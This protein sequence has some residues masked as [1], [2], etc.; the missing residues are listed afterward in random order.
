MSG[1]LQLVA[2]T[3]VVG[4]I[5]PESVPLWASP[6][7]S[8][9]QEL[10]LEAL[11]ERQDAVF[12]ETGEEPDWA[13]TSSKQYRLLYQQLQAQVRFNGDGGLQAG[14]K[15][16]LKLGKTLVERQPDCP[17]RCFWL[18]TKSD[19]I[20][21]RGEGPQWADEKYGGTSQPVQYVSGTTKVK[22]A[23]VYRMQVGLKQRNSHSGLTA[24]K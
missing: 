18:L 11:Y 16:G 24:L 13:L 7:D 2:E 19:L 12:Q 20:A 9:E 6:V 5:N 10:S 14:D 3:G 1:L 15:E 22:G 21:I 17:D 4:N 8:T 23:L